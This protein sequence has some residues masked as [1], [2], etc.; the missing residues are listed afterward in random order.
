LAGFA[1]LPALGCDKGGSG[2]GDSD[3]DSDGDSDTDSDGDS[4]S[5]SDGDSDTDSDGD[6]DTDSDTDADTDTDTDTDADGDLCDD[7]PAADNSFAVGDVIRN[8]TLW[9]RDDMEHQMCEYGG[10]DHT[11]LFLAITS[12]T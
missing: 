9:D 1:F 4:D 8:Y 3:S 10:G 5:D 6:S 7:Y 11:L 2:D 12:T